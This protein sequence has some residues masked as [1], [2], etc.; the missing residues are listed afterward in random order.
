MN[1]IGI[2]SCFGFVVLLLGL[3]VAARCWRSRRSGWL[4]L[5]HRYP[6]G[7]R[8]TPHH[9]GQATARI[10]GLFYSRQLDI[11]F[12][13]AGMRIAYELPLRAFH[14][15]M[16]VPWDDVTPDAVQ[17]DGTLP[18]HVGDSAEI[19]LTGQAAVAAGSLLARRVEHSHRR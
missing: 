10:N 17:L 3:G 19:T 16:F 4:A 7:P 2:V 6:A 12:S 1:A 18:L 14:P 8:V 15:P 11:S 13:G 9:F 5:G